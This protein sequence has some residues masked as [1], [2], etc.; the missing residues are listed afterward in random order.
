MKSQ[1]HEF[2]PGILSSTTIG[3]EKLSKKETCST[4]KSS[5]FQDEF[6]QRD[7]PSQKVIVCFFNLQFFKKC[8]Y[9][10]FFYKI[11]CSRAL[12]KLVPAV[13]QYQAT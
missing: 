1:Y 6:P 2:K 13:K 8:L 5:Q 9:H 3:D 4:L 11:S 12:K 10:Y 7:I